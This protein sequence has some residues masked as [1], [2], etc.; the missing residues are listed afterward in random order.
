MT[1]TGYLVISDISGYSKFLHESELDH[2][3]ESLEDLLNLLVGEMRSPLRIVELEGDA[4]FSYAPADEVTSAEMT[5]S[6]QSTGEPPGSASSHRRRDDSRYS[7][8]ICSARQER[9]LQ[10]ESIFSRSLTAGEIGNAENI[11]L[12]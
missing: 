4:V 7:K 9:W 3:R 5:P 2:A 6:R 11:I 10:N 8:G 1:Q 12:S